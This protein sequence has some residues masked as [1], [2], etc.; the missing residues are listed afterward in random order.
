M[1]VFAPPAKL[2]ARVTVSGLHTG[3]SYTLSRFT[4][5]PVANAPSEGIESTV[6]FTASAETWVYADPAP[7]ASDGAT[8]YVATALEAV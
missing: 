5:L 7:F 2:H 6:N 1:R 8:Y 4:G 3:S